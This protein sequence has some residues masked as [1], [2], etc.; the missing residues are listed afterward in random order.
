MKKITQIASLEGQIETLKIERTLTLKDL[1][2]HIAFGAE[3]L[4][5]INILKSTYENLVSDTKLPNNIIGKALG[6]GAGILAKRAFSTYKKGLVGTVGGLVLQYFVTKKVA[7]N[8]D[9]L[10]NLALDLFNKIRNRGA[11]DPIQ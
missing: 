1:K 4:R 10:K 6:F 9:S 11:S 2:D 3:Q 8:S 5:P 7:N